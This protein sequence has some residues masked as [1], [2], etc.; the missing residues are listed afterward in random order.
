VD[1]AYAIAVAKS[2]YRDGY[3]EGNIEKVLSVFANGFVDM[4]EGQPSIFGSDA[5]QALRARLG[6]LFAQYRVRLAPLIVDVV[7]NGNQAYDFGWHKLHLVSADGSE[8]EL[9]M[10]YFERW[11]KQPDGQW[12]IVYIIT[13]KEEQPGMEPLSESQVMGRLAA[14][15]G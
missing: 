2:E 11:S 15:E 12:K 5:R 8:R 3:N 14:L 1:D 7:V 13:N 10:R 9:R 4:S 6:D